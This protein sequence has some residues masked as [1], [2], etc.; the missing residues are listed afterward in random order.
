MPTRSVPELLE[1]RVLQG[2]DRLLQAGLALADAGEQR[3]EP[4]FVHA[5]G[6]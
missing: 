1:G 6:E 3:A 4:S 2:L 5:A